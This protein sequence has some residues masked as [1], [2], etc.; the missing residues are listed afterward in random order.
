VPRESRIKSYEIA[1][2]EIGRAA[3]HQHRDL[4]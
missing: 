3:G 1:A 2:P 4:R